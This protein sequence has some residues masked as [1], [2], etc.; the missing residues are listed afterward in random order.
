VD[1]PANA[2]QLHTEYA[3]FCLYLYALI[4]NVYGCRFEG[5]QFAGSLAVA[6]MMPSAFRV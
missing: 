6:L 3:D 5:L 4:F 1:V 2:A